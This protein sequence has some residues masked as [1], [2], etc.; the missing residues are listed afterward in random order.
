MVPNHRFIVDDLYD[1][2]GYDLTSHEGQARFVDDA[3]AALHAHDQRWGFLKKTGSGAQIHGHSEDGALYLSDTPGQSQHVDFIANAGATNAGIGWSV[4]IPRY[5]RSD[6]YPPSEHP[7]LEGPEPGEPTP[8]HICP[9]VPVVPN[10]DEALDELNWL[11]A[12]YS[13]PD[14]LQRSNGL[15]L[16]GK[17]DFLGIAAWYL[18]VYQRE[19][20]NGK[21]RADARA[22]YVS[23]IRH[24]DEW[25]TK[26]PGETP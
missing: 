9:P 1:H 15:S 20:I 22:V 5:S 8:P 7:P 6:W 24:S 23:D 4:D 13:A 14:G 2:G 18:D 16:N 26:H 21:S 10:R 25:K 3:V 12:Y 11:D 17:P 19:R